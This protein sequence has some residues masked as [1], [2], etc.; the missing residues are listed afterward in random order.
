ML[1]LLAVS[2]P[3]GFALAAQ[4]E[5]GHPLVQ[6]LAKSVALCGYAI[7]ALQPVLAA[8]YRWLERPFGLDALY[9]FHR[10]MGLVA[11]MLLL[12]HPILYAAG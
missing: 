2:A 8:R 7:L 12:A 3:L 1:Y 4:R 9:R 11:G 10:S 5:T 6:E